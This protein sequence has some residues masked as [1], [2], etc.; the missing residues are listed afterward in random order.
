LDVPAGIRTVRGLTTQS[1]PAL[2]LDHPIAALLPLFEALD[3]HALTDEYGEEGERPGTT[4]GI[5]VFVE[6]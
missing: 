3:L 1:S 5:F 4:I 6:R 2:G